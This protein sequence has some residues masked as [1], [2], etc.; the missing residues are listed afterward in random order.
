LLMRSS[1]PVPHRSLFYKVKPFA[2]VEFNGEPIKSV[3]TALK[4]AVKLADLS[5]KIT[6]RHTDATWLMQFRVDKWEAAGF[7]GMSVETLERVYGRR[8]PDYLKGAATALTRG[9]SQSL[10]IF[11]GGGANEA[12]RERTTYENIG[13]GRS[14]IRTRLCSQI[15]ANREKNREFLNAGDRDVCKN[16]QCQSI[17]PS[18]VRHV[19]GRGHLLN[20]VR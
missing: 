9:K 2:T 8:H 3:K 1:E 6:L 19:D 4:S 11:I 5:R 16:R 10:V 13:G 14:H 18:I 17:Q 20:A 12:T 7:L 15:P